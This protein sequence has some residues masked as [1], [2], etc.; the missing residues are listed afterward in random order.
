MPRRPR[1]ATV[2]ALA[3][4]SAAACVPT[5]DA[6]DLQRGAA[7][8]PT[9]SGEQA[10]DAV[11]SYVEMIN[12]GLRGGGVEE[13]A[14]VTDQRCSCYALVDMIEEGTTGGGELV[15]AEFS[16]DDLSVRSA[17]GARAVVRARIGITAY[18]VRSADGVVVDRVPS[19]SYV[20]DYTVHTDGDRWRVVEVAPV[21]PGQ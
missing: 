14:E 21:G 3:A 12:E 1:T 16:A 5:P 6:A 4:M 10:V 18:R 7:E 15:G 9:L 19:E 2:V 8:G 13:L 17:E 20:A 11:G